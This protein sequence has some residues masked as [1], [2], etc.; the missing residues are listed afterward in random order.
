[1][2]TFLSTATAA[3]LLQGAVSFWCL[4]DEFPTGGITP[5]HPARKPA[6][7]AKRVNR[8]ILVLFMLAFTA[9]PNV[10]ESATP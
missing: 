1:M 4:C 9:V 8:N 2:S 7:S 10:S 6:E 3:L 5:L